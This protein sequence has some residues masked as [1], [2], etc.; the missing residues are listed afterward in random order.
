M[1]IRSYDEGAF[2]LDAV[3]AQKGG[4]RVSVC[5]PAH[6]EAATVGAIV[7]DVRDRLV[8]AC[9]LV[10]EIVVVDDGSEDG[11]EAIALAAGARAVPANGSTPGHPVGKGGAMRTAAAHAE[12]DVI[13]FLDADVVGGGSAF[14][15]GLLGPILTTPGTVL[16]KATY[17]RS[18]HGED[19]EGGR[20]NAL[21]A[22][23]LL[24]RL[25]P[26]LAR[27]QQPLAGECAITRDALDEIKLADGYGVEIAMLIDIA[28]R[29]GAAAIA[30]VDLGERVLRNRPLDQLVV[31]ATEVLD[32]ALTR[33]GRPG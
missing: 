20:V 2:S 29:F 23:P 21:V 9:P 27:L 4:R 30:E 24:A 7:H 10:D 31:H 18:L 32:A 11:T 6:N 3:L 26:H 25:F 16:S 13:V 8:A 15:V 14:V 22:R 5:L 1:A 17:R 28:E 12:G 19:G 33:H